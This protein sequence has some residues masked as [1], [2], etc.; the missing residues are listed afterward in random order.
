MI[1]VPSSKS[2]RTLAFTPFRTP[3]V[4]VTLPPLSI[5]DGGGGICSRSEVESSI[6]HTNDCVAVFTPSL[7]ATTTLKLPPAVGVPLIAPVSVLIVRPA[8]RP[9]AP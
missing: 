2:Q 6:V 5:G 3:A 1:G 4:Y 9:L 7:A 8:G